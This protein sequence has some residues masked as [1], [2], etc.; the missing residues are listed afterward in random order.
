VLLPAIMA[1]PLCYFT[2]LNSSTGKIPWESILLYIALQVISDLS[3]VIQK[4]L[5][6]PLRNQADY[7]IRTTTF[8]HIMDQSLSFHTSRHSGK[9]WQAVLRGASVVE[10]VRLVVFDIWPQM[11]D[12]VIAVSVLYH[13]FGPYMALLNAAV[14]IFFLWS[15]SRTTSKQKE[16]R[17]Q[18]NSDQDKEHDILCEATGNWETVLYCNRISDT[19]A[20]YSAA[21]HD[22]I[23]SS[24]SFKNW[25]SFTSAMQSFLMKIGLMGACFIAAEQV[26]RVNQDVGSFFMLLN[27][28]N[29]LSGPLRFFA[30]GFSYLTVNLAAAEGLI[31]LLKQQP[32]ITDECDTELMV[33]RG[34]I[35]FHS[36][37]FS[38]KDKVPLLKHITIWVPGGRRI[39]IVGRSG[40][41]K[42]TI[43]RLILRL[44]DPC[45]GTITIDGKN[46]RDVTQESLRANIGVVPQN[47]ALFNNT[48]INNI[49][50]ANPLAT[51]NEVFE[52][53]KAVGL[54]D[55]FTDPGKFPLGYETVVGERGARLSGGQL[56]R[57]AIARVLVQNPMIVLLDEATSSVDSETESE[58]LQSFRRLQTGRTTITIAYVVASPIMIQWTDIAS[59]HRLS[60]IVDADEIWFL[61]DGKIVEKGSHKDL[62][63]KDGSYRRLWLRQH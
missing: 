44:C 52:A 29:Q 19:K 26:I 53:C 61:Q 37:E 45:Q 50:Y 17:Q 34:E 2:E 60:T 9:I 55:K 54:H 39:G 35:E 36:V 41:G 11:F 15:S 5:W 43:L 13:F 8:N 31:Q 6:L 42:S 3:L 30:E 7:R 32:T 4:R 57:V 16:K 10:I 12:L 51:D 25:S 63:S 46:I 58:I 21:V 38:Y 48:I 47:P 62:L 23:N 24:L 14:A 20:E 49:K 56:Q 18:F 33:H 1:V 22:R 59:R 40:E 28:W 27:Y